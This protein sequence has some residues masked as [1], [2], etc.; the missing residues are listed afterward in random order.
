MELVEAI[1]T[2]IANLLHISSDVIKGV[3]VEALPSSLK[4]N[5]MVA[6]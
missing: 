5:I 4:T 3:S 6:T 1:K 2:D